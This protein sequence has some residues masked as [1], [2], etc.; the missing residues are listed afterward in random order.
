[1]SDFSEEHLADCDVCYQEYQELEL[2]AAAE[3]TLN[4]ELTVMGEYLNDR[5]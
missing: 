5:N 2:E 1:M 3:F 4:N